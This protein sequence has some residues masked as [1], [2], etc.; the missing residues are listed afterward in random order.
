MEKAGGGQGGRDEQMQTGGT[1]HTHSAAPRCCPED[2]IHD[3]GISG[4]GKEHEKECT[5]PRH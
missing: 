2:S 5:Y 1:G 4:D 3:P